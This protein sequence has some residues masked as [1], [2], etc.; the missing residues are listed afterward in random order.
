MHNGTSADSTDEVLGY[1]GDRPCSKEKA[2]GQQ[3]CGGVHRGVEML[4]KEQ[5][6]LACLGC[7]GS[8]HSFFPCFETDRGE[9]NVTQEV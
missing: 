5:L 8:T 2:A 4:S 3:D 7:F 1:L 6:R 9:A